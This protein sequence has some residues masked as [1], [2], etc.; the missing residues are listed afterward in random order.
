MSQMQNEKNNMSIQ[1][2]DTSTIDYRKILL[3]SIV[4]MS[5]IWINH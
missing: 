1:I 4:D 5:W 2:Q 3:Q